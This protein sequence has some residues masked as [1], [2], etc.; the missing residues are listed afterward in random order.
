MKK[1]ESEKQLHKDM[2]SKIVIG[3]LKLNC[4]INKNSLWIS[5]SVKRDIYKT[6]YS[7]LLRSHWSP[8][9]GYLYLTHLYL[10]SIMLIRHNASSLLMWVTSFWPTPNGNTLDLVLALMHF[11]TDAWLGLVSNQLPG[12]LSVKIWNTMWLCVHSKLAC[13]R[14]LK[15]F[16]A[17]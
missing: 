3:Q 15:T 9:E 12:L 10:G 2:K 14:Q 4:D 17:N 6:L 8:G 5:N 11:W 7:F 16:L 1:K 13:V